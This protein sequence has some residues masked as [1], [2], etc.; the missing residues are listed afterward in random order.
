MADNW[1]AGISGYTDMMREVRQ[2]AMSILE[3]N[4]ACRLLNP[5]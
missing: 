3:Q 5:Q 1:Y 2:A 4:A